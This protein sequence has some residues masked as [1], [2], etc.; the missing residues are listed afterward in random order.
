[1]PSRICRNFY[2]NPGT[3]KNHLAYYFASFQLIIKHSLDP[4]WTSE[5]ETLHYKYCYGYLVLPE[6]TDDYLKDVIADQQT[7]LFSDTIEE[8]FVSL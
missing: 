7:Y 6:K 8:L 2:Y 4:P 5:A 3:R 1:M